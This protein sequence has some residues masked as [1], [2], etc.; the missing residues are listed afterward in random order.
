MS[1]EREAHISPGTMLLGA[2]AARLAWLRRPRRNMFLRRPRR[3]RSRAPNG[4]SI[5]TRDE[6]SRIHVA[7]RASQPHPRRHRRAELNRSG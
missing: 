5:P 1:G 4:A 2:S 3:R 6:A 7:T